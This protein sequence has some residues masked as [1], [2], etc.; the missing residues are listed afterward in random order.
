MLALMISG[1]PEQPAV[2][3]HPGGGAGAA[4]ALRG[5]EAGHHPLRTA[6]PPGQP[7]L[8]ASRQVPTPLFFKI[9]A[10]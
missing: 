4:P 9:R 7:A 3:L 8:Q 1:E 6:P 2:R 5:D 10:G